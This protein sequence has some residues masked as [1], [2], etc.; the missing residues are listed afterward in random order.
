MLHSSV[1]LKYYFDNCFILKLVITSA[2]SSAMNEETVLTVFIIFSPK[3]PEF[4]S[5]L[6]KEKL[7]PRVLA[8]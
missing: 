3:L 5:A 6:H 2:T 7:L 8:R 4:V 1:F